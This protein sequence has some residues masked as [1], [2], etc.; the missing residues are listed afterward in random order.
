MM[1]I[2]RALT[3]RAVG[4]AA[5]ACAWGIESD[6]RGIEDRSRDFCMR[7]SFSRLIGI[8]SSHGGT[9]SGVAND[10]G[11]GIYARRSTSRAFV[12]DQA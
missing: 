8:A 2:K 10:A 12:R 3:R 5:V 6:V 4:L 7:T 9:V 11:G 1:A